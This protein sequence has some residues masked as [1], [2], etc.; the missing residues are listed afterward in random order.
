MSNYKEIN[1]DVIRAD[2]VMNPSYP[3]FDEICKRHGVSK[4]TVISKA[5]D[6]SDSINRG[7]TWSQQREKYVQKKQSVQEDAAVNEAKK[8]IAV[9]VKVLNNVGLKA[10]KLID[11]EL[12][13]LSREQ[14]D[15]LAKNQHFPIRKYVKINDITKIAEVLH[16]LSGSESKE[17]LVKL[18]LAG[19]KAEDNKIR[20][21]DLSDEE[22]DQVDRQ[23][24]SGR[25]LQPIDT[26]FEVIEENDN[27]S[28]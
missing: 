24:K 7:L 12:D 19:K 20:L 1:W 14:D 11:K 17:L 3:S 25:T 18:E 28:D 21:Q 22:L 6:V 10:F 13:Y 8:A 15:A 16:K 23:V 5:N 27:G 9:Y 26:E 2:Y 4:P